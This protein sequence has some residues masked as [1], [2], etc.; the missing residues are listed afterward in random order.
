MMSLLIV[1]LSL[2][3]STATA[4]LWPPMV[5]GAFTNATI[6]TNFTI[7]TDTSTTL[8]GTTLR[9]HYCSDGYYCADNQNCC[10]AGYCCP[11]GS[12]C[13]G[14]SEC[15]KSTS[16]ASP[17]T[18]IAAIAIMVVVLGC[19]KLFFRSLCSSLCS[20]SDSSSSS[21]TAYRRVNN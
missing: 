7:D 11:Y 12:V 3:L 19:L 20:S 9:E 2:F 6:G 4:D 15:Q 16:S 8:R 13:Y 18:I 14:I 21:A 5:T 1:F 17:V 10:G